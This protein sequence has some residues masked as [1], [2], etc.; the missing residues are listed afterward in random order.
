MKKI[1]TMMLCATIS[2]LTLVGCGEE[3][4]ENISSPVE[5]TNQSTELK[6]AKNGHII[7]YVYEFSDGYSWIKVVDTET[8]DYKKCRYAFINSSG[9]IEFFLDKKIE[10]ATLYAGGYK[11]GFSLINNGE[12]ILVMNT[13]GE[14]LLSAT[15]VGF[16]DILAFGDGYF[17]VQKYVNDFH[18]AEY[19]V[20]VI[21]QQGNMIGDYLASQP[22]TFDSYDIDCLQEGI[23]TYPN[24]DSKLFNA[25]T[26]KPIE[27]NPNYE[28]NEIY[29]CFVNGNCLVSVKDINTKDYQLALLHKDGSI[30]TC[31][32]NNPS[33]LLSNGISDDGFIYSTTTD[34]SVE[35]L[36][37]YDLLSKKSNL[38]YSCGTGIELP[39]Q[40][41][42]GPV[43]KN[44]GSNIF[45]FNNGYS[46]IL[47]RSNKSSYFTVVDKL[48]NIQ[49]EPKECYK[50]EG[51]SCNRIVSEQ[52]GDCKIFTE[53]GEE[54][55]IPDDYII[56]QDS[57]SDNL[58]AVHK[59]IDEEWS[60]CNYIDIDGNLLFENDMIYY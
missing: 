54:I 9:E 50:A 55:P 46:T 40:T 24:N 42:G 21:D 30:E 13:Q 29:D 32:T 3:R 15:E 14:I 39:I 57:Y 44:F 7:D 5:D 49:F 36:Y 45:S 53:K 47:I 12:E 1:I 6:N 56:H 17:A 43:R 31:K 20:F 34:N 10:G 59:E 4:K 11:D 16:D 33:Y 26:G 41:G 18:T 60:S 22:E 19:K 25:K 58:I 51:I 35:Y 37:F 48:G 23:F 27:I 8:E 2:L 28:I 52:H 38:I